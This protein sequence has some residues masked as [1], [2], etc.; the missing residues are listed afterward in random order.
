MRSV[1][2]EYR[3]I[4]LE[5][6]ILYF[7]FQ[8]IRGLKVNKLLQIKDFKIVLTERNYL[9]SKKPIFQ[10]HHVKI[11]RPF[12]QQIPKITNGY[13]ATLYGQI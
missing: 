12:M 13:T 7:N 8:V 1:T 11:V 5:T 2:K 10:Y 6:K 9:E 4:G 3:A